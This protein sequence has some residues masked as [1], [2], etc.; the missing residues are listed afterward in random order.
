[1]DLEELEPRKRQDYEI[2]G[3]LSKLSVGE[4]NELVETLTKEI[5]RVQEAIGA[6]ELSL[7]AADSVFKP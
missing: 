4:L 1:M 7:Q 5:A 6:K 2:G 3:D